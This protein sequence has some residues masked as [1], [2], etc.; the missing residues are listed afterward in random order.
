MIERV[1]SRLYKY[2]QFK[3]TTSEHFARRINIDNGYKYLTTETLRKSENKA[4]NVY[5]DENDEIAGLAH[6]PKYLRYLN[7]LKE[8]VDDGANASEL[9]PGER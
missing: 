3:S 5:Y 9:S 4:S 2:L 1:F 6:A 8:Y 7:K